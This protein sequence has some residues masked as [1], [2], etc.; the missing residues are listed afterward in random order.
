[1][2]RNRNKQRNTLPQSSTP[3]RWHSQ[4]EQGSLTNG[5]NEQGEPASQEHVRGES[6]YRS[7]ENERYGNDWNP[8]GT[9]AG[10]GYQSGYRSGS[11]G[12]YQG[13]YPDEYQSRSGREYGSQGAWYGS[14]QYGSQS[15]INQGHSQQGGYGTS[16]YSGQYGNPYGSQYGGRYGSQYGGQY[17]GQHESQYRS[18]S[19]GGYQSEYGSQGAQYDDG[20]G[21][22]GT[23]SAYGAQYRGNENQGGYGSYGQS[24]SAQQGFSSGQYGLRSQRGGQVGQYGAHDRSGMTYGPMGG[25]QDYSSTPWGSQHQRRGKGPKGYQRSDERIKEDV[26]EALMDAGIDASEVEVEV[27]GG[28][29]TLTG[30]VS[31]REDR[32]QAEHVAVG[33][34]GVKDVENNVRVKRGDDQPTGIASAVGRATSSRA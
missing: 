4:S 27:S 14:G 8:R 28:V 13:G 23:S 26:N 20:C 30:T 5:S 22:P 21:C 9:G 32:Y 3:D 25:K 29:V 10:S 17:G 2:S 12:E 18:Q 33:C 16:P 15:Q 34:S 24:G 7:S 1:M 6:G 31:Q 11:Q 19:G